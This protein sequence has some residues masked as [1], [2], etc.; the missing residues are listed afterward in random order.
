MGR[1]LFNQS[2][3]WWAFG[4]FPCLC[5]CRQ[6]AA[7]PL[8]GLLSPCAGV[9]SID[10]A[11]GAGWCPLAG[12]Y[13]SRL[14]H[15][16]RSARCPAAQPT[17]RHACP[18]IVGLLLVVGGKWSFRIVLIYI[19]L[20]RRLSIFMWVSHFYIVFL[21][22]VSVQ[23]FYPITYYHWCCVYQYFVLFYGWI[24][25]HHTGR[26]IFLGS[27]IRWCGGRLG[28]LHL[29]VL[30]NG[31]ALSLL[32]SVLRCWEPP[33]HCRKL[34]FIPFYCPMTFLIMTVSPFSHS[35][36]DGHVGHLL[37]CMFSC[38]LLVLTFFWRAYAREWTWLIKGLCVFSFTW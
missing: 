34:S 37:L 18:L 20:T 33:S 24:L 26:H 32:H 23:I 13:S 15:V 17:D 4:S 36:H 9:L 29:L 28:C 25:F 8:P 27:C 5:C 1:S 6:P 21:R 30:V 35:S 38:V 10:S 19:S 14:D 16:G 11:V 7:E 12:I 3:E 2:P 31:P 22:E